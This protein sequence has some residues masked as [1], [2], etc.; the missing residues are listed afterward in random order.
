MPN[1]VI[2]N[3]SIEDCHMLLDHVILDHG[4][5]SINTCHVEFV[6]YFNHEKYKANA[7]I[8]HALLVCNVTELKILVW[9]DDEFLKDDQSGY[10]LQAVKKVGTWLPKP[11]G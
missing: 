3:E 2:T 5:A 9:F 11:K 1:V 7:W 4:D 6:N 10:H 8:F